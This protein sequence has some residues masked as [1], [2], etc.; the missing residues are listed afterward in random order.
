MMAT[1]QIFLKEQVHHSAAY[2]ISSYYTIIFKEKVRKSIKQFFK[3]LIIK[4]MIT[5]MQSSRL[6][7]PFLNTSSFGI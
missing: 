6:R 7:S 5:T 1:N 2:M 3:R 4:G